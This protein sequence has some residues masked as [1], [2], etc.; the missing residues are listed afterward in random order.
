[1]LVGV[2]LGVRVGVAEGVT[3]GVATGNSAT[4]VAVGA[5]A[6]VVNSEMLRH[7]IKSEDLMFVLSPTTRHIQR[8]S[9][10]PN[11]T[12]IESATRWC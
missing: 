1:M 11:L 9:G 12:A 7:T 5:G 4:D 10:Q 2:G 8:G 3:V 6:H